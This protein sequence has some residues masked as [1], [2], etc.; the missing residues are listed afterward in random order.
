MDLLLPTIATT[1]AA[2]NAVTSPS[3]SR[4]VENSI[5]RDESRVA[6]DDPTRIE[7]SPHR[8]SV[9]AAKTVSVDEATASPH[10]YCSSWQYV[11]DETW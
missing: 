2:A 11:W 9:L 7:E 5:D 3:P 8:T 10:R 1:A 6:D 4:H